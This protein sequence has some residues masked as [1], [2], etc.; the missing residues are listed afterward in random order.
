MPPTFLVLSVKGSRETVVA[1]EE[2]DE[3]FTWT[4]LRLRC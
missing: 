1:L 3:E 2:G 4:M